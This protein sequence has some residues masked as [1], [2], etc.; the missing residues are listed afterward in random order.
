MRKNKKI[1]LAIIMA[2]AMLFNCAAAVFAGS[3][4][5]FV[6]Y[7]TPYAFALSS[8]LAGYTDYEKI[9]LSDPTLLWYVITSYWQWI[10][11]NE[12]VDYLT[13]DQV[14]AAQEVFNP[15]FKFI[16]PTDDM[17]EYGDVVIEKKDGTEIYR[18]PYRQSY[19]DEYNGSDEEDFEIYYSD[20][21][22]VEA[23]YFVLFNDEEGSYYC[24][25]FVFEF[26]ANRRSTSRMS[27]ALRPKY[28]LSGMELPSYDIE[29]DIDEIA[30][31][32]RVSNLLEKYDNIFYHLEY[33]DG[34]IRDSFYLNYNGERAFIAYTGEL[35]EDYYDSSYSAHY[36]G[37]DFYEDEEGKIMVN[38][39]LLEED[40]Y[41]FF[42]YSLVDD[43]CDE[44]VNYS[45]ESAEKYHF[46]SYNEFYENGYG[47]FNSDTYIMDRETLEI[48]ENSYYYSY[49]YDPAED[50]EDDEGT[51][52]SISGT[53]Y[54]YYDE[55]DNEDPIFAP[56]AEWGKKLRIV[57][58]Q[59]G[60]YNDDGKLEFTR[61]IVK[62]PKPWEYLPYEAFYGYYS[63]FM[64]KAGT[65]EYAYPGHNKNY[66]IYLIPVEE[67]GVG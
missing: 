38:S 11:E 24:Y 10:Y 54:T 27:T 42:D 43:R 63:V 25:D 59:I 67:P 22:E 56:F 8:G 2:A 7:V 13:K 58:V 64:D 31:A 18:F 9:D 53:I 40:D 35:E 60:E 62:V 20:D 49:Y 17:I 50:D 39:S 28:I 30:E 55:I 6:E 61:H 23:Y 16:A 32:N 46:S 29:Y 3:E 37:F 51:Y 1:L 5:D 47:E 34:T 41:D 65:K 33:D 36:N 66:T 44:E 19:I 26:K 45:G 48:T 14:S 57:T 12:G 4:D 52:D 15:G 21:N